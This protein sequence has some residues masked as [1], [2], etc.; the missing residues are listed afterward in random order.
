MQ[1][2]TSNYQIVAY[3]PQ[4]TA[5][6]NF[7]A[8]ELV[9]N[10]SVNKITVIN[11]AFGN[12]GDGK[13]IMTTQAGVMDAFSDYQRA[14]STE[15][16]VDGIADTADQPLRGNFNQLKKLKALNP[17]LKIVISLGGWTWSKG[18]SDAALTS[19]S[20]TAVVQSCIDIYIKGNLPVV[21]QAGGE[22]SGRRL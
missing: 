10:G 4:W 14:F 3:F 13:C 22:G 1:A 15:E 20:R 7:F 2:T 21:D 9:S 19:E 18:F 11:Y 17:N 12:I 5:D 8:K 16:S 6:N